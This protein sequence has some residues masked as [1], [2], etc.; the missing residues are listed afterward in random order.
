M[1][2]KEDKQ[3]LINWIN[4]WETMPKFFQI[5]I[6]NE[7]FANIFLG[8]KDFKNLK[9]VLSQ[10]KQGEF[11]NYLI[12]LLDISND[13]LLQNLDIVLDDDDNP[14]SLDKQW[15]KLKPQLLSVLKVPMKNLNQISKKLRMTLSHNNLLKTLITA[16]KSTKIIVFQQLINRM[17]NGVD[18]VS[19]VTRNGKFIDINDNEVI[20]EEVNEYLKNALLYASYD[21]QYLQ[22][23]YPNTD[24]SKRLK[25]EHANIE[26][27]NISVE[28]FTGHR[29][30]KS[31]VHVS[32]HPKNKQPPYSLI[33]VDFTLKNDTLNSL[34]FETKDGP[35]L[36]RSEDL[37]E[38][39]KDIFENL[40]DFS[41]KYI[42]KIKGKQRDI[43]LDKKDWYGFTLAELGN[44][45]K[46]DVMR[47]NL[48]L[49]KDEVDSLHLF[50]VLNRI[51]VM[52][53]YQFNYILVDELLSTDALLSKAFRNLK[54]EFDEVLAEEK[55]EDI[56]NKMITDFNNFKNTHN[57]LVR[58]YFDVI[59]KDGQSVSEE[60]WEIIKNPNK[61]KA[62]KY[63][64]LDEK[65]YKQSF[66]LK[67]E[68]AEQ[69][70]G[71]DQFNI[72]NLE[73]NDKNNE[74]EKVNDT[75]ENIK[76]KIKK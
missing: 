47:G 63:R 18:A 57:S 69:D 56:R 24:F 35:T 14:K 19:V 72:F 43:T 58:H 54:I 22:E 52:D 13:K 29:I 71:Y 23:N 6:S 76:R 10:E 61:S 37:L 25:L 26:Y 36:E 60:Q 62:E 65:Y 75:Q 15:F 55:S 38:T 70:L 2:L 28:S 12:A 73:N 44:N 68:V 31:F 59:S 30:L 20:D 49:F 16:S 34:T 74:Q 7:E 42:P 53:E 64:L 3:K 9:N 40:Y 45:G 8:L 48:P 33:G 39:K 41:S 46:F 51:F 27:K 50:N 1:G 17:V 66:R 11:I 21:E 4:S 32:E 67:K 5:L